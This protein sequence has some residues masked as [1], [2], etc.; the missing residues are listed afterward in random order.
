MQVLH[1]AL[2]PLTCIQEAKPAWA[3]EQYPRRRFASKGY[4]C[5]DLSFERLAFRLSAYH[6][7]RKMPHT[8]SMVRSVP[9]TTQ[10]GDQPSSRCSGWPKHGCS[11]RVGWMSA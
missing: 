8:N 2:L 7:R 3:A 10:R 6:Y 11:G 4:P 5:P 9:Y 1:R